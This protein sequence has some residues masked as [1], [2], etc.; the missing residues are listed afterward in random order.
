MKAS[1]VGAGLGLALYAAPT[2]SAACSI[3]GS[4][5]LSDAE[6]CAQVRQAMGKVTT[7][8]LFEV[9]AVDAKPVDRHPD[10][11]SGLATV[12]PLET[13]QG[14]LVTETATYPVF[15][16]LESSSC[17]EM[18]PNVGHRFVGFVHGD[19]RQVLSVDLMQ[20]PETF[21]RDLAACA[22]AG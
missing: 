20:N 12:R 6:R 8:A 2:L 9:V 15:E 17:P 4:V 22:S 14:G 1:I 13:Y 19:G 16:D 3:T 7:V 11:L 21:D 18:L 10:V 5:R